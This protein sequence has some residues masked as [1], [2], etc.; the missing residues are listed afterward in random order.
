MLPEPKPAVLNKYVLEYSGV[1]PAVEVSEDVPAMII[2]I[3]RAHG[4]YDTARIAYKQQQ[5]GLRYFARSRWADTPAR[6]LA[7]RSQ[8]L[9]RAATIAQLSLPFFRTGQTIDAAQM[10]PTYI[11]KSDAELSLKS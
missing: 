5:F 6:M 4:G 11:R 2:T 10:A 7:P 9:I 8:H 3:P 1:R